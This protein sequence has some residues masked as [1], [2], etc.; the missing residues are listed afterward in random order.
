MKT[1]TIL[2]IILSILTSCDCNQQVAGTVVDKE[3]GRP[4][5]DVTV[6]NKSKEY[7]ITTTDSTG[8]FELSNISGGLRC[9]PMTVIATLNNYYKVEV[10]I[11]AGGIVTIKMQKFHLQK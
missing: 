7:I 6:Y 2:I 9:P 5:Q 3:T 4:L 1:I 11:P 10:S 8:Y